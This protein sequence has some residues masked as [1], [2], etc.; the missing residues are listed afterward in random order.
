MWFAVWGSFY[1]PR[2]LRYQEP[3]G[4]VCAVSGSCVV[5]FLPSIKGVFSAAALHSQVS[6]SSFLPRTFCGCQVPRLADQAS[7]PGGSTAITYNKA[8]C[9][10][11]FNTAQQSS[12]ASHYA[13]N[14]HSNFTALN[15]MCI[16]SAG[17]K[18]IEL[19]Y[20]NTL[21]NRLWK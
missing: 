17:L 1:V 12:S 20:H 9:K 11:L 18:F 8:T 14:E 16:H 15:C 2:T 21:A 3:N 5:C 6:V 7:S 13:K 4:I 10:S 19:I